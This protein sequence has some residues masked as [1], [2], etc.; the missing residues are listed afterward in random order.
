M[1][2]QGGSFY[3]TDGT[4]VTNYSKLPILH[5]SG[6]RG[7]VMYQ[8][9]SSAQSD[10]NQWIPAMPRAWCWEIGYQ[11]NGAPFCVFQIKVDA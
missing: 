2:Y 3:Q 9:S 10:P 1:Y 7:S 11:T 8:Y 4:F 6:Q 5:D